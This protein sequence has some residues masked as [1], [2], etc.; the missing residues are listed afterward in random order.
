[1]RRLALRLTPP[2]SPV[3]HD[4]GMGLLF[5]YFAANSD[6]DAGTAIYRLGG[7][8]AHS[9]PGNPPP[10]ERRGWF[11]RSPAT[12]DA[13][14]GLIPAAFDTVQDTG[15][16]PVVQMGTLEELLTGRP[17]DEVVADPRSGHQI[18][19]RDNGERAVCTVTQ[20]LTEALANLPRARAHEVA[21]AWAQTEEFWGAADPDDLQSVLLDLSALADRA[22]ANGQSLY[23]W[24]CV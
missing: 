9:A 4:P 21:A 17:Y 8:G 23:C 6:E 19:I 14:A 13:T 7:P 1:M 11:R 15:I 3:V 12:P 24:A 16:D 2:G 22:R 5:D 10:S 20:T 18:A